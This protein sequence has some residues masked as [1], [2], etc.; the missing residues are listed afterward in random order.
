MEKVVLYEA[1]MK[2]M[3]CV[4]A[5]LID[6]FHYG[7]L[8]VL[9]K[10]FIIEL[11]CFISYDWLCCQLSNSNRYQGEDPLGTYFV[12]RWMKPSDSADSY[13]DNIHRDEQTDFLL[14]VCLSFILYFGQFVT[15]YH[16]IR[17]SWQIMT[18][19]LYIILQWEIWL[20][21]C[22]DDCRISFRY[23]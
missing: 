7:C 5:V 15:L 6:M 19:A 8:F 20:E 17:S 10:K 9:N 2:V 11:I 13:I 23:L 1:R 3:D 14:I 4:N 16:I 12:K 21:K 18:S 22:K